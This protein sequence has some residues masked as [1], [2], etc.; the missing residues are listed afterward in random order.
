MVWLIETL[1]L[2]FPSPPQCLPSRH[3]QAVNDVAFHPTESLLASGSQDRTIC[4][5]DHSKKEKRAAHRISETYPVRTLAF[6]PTGDYMLGQHER[7]QHSLLP[8]ATQARA[9][10]LGVVFGVPFPNTIARVSLSWGARKRSM[11]GSTMGDGR[12][13]VRS[14][15]HFGEWVWGTGRCPRGKRGGDGVRKGVQRTQKASC[16]LHRRAGGW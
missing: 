8:S 10:R 14:W 1:H 13:G 6:H 3:S 9:A 4:L 12:E 11:H 7:V 5:F 15:V 16:E 2:S